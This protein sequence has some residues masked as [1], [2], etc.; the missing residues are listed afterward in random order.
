MKLNS[1]IIGCVLLVFT[2]CKTEQASRKHIKDVRKFLIETSLEGQLI[3]QIKENIFPTYMGIK[4]SLL[5]LCDF[6]AS[7]HF[8]TYNIK[9]FS[10]L[11]SFGMQGRGPGD[12]QD[13][14]FSSQI[15]K[16]NNSYGVWVYQMNRMRLTCNDIFRSI[17]DMDAK[18]K[19]TIVLPPEANTACNVIIVNQNLVIGSGIDA[20][21]EFF[22]YDI[23]KDDFRWK[24]HLV[25]HDI[26]C[27]KNLEQNKLLG[28]YKLGTLKVKPDGTSFVKA[29]LFQPLIDVYN[30]KLDILFTIKTGDYDEPKFMESNNNFIGTSNAYYANVFLTD[31]Y[32]YALNYNCHYQDMY[33]INVRNAEMHIFNWSGDAVCRIKLNQG[34][35]PFGP[36]AVDDNNTMIIKSEPAEEK[37]NFSVFR[38]DSLLK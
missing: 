23:M 28:Q 10:Y 2:G 31:E 4:D 15:Q 18:P 13:P 37:D 5:V 7:P 3:S 27:L 19:K 16:E 25:D 12:I 36:F 30:K 35:T 20:Q 32:I 26:A 22:I 1:L 33:N 14:F 8:Y 6:K 9:D 34:I 17:N 38:I 29:Y 11:G 21:G 24:K